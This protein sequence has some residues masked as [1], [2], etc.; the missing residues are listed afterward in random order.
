MCRFYLLPGENGF[1]LVNYSFMS[2]FVGLGQYDNSAQSLLPP[3]SGQA[4]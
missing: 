2:A 4:E 3:I 1:G